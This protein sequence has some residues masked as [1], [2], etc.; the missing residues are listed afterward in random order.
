M[1]EIKPIIKNKNA[2]T[3]RLEDKITVIEHGYF[4]EG[5]IEIKDTK[6][7]DVSQYAEAQVVDENLVSE[8][9]L[10]DKTI[11]GIEGQIELPNEWN[12]E[13]EEE[14]YDVGYTLWDGTY[15]IEGTE[16]AVKGVPIVVS[17][18]EEIPN[19]LK[20]NLVGN[21]IYYV[22]ETTQ[23][24][25][26]NNYYI[27]YQNTNN[28]ISLRRVITPQD[29]L[30][31]KYNGTFDV[32]EYANVFI[33]V[34][35]K[36]YEKTTE[37]ME[38]FLLSEESEFGDVVLNTDINQYNV[39]ISINDVKNYLKLEEEVE[40]W[41]GSYSE[42]GKVLSS[43]DGSYSEIGN[44]IL[45]P[46]DDGVGGIPIEVSSIEQMDALLVAENI[47]KIYKYVGETNE[48]YTNGALYQISEEV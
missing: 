48:K 37:E 30:E 3:I 7:V 29:T 39:I 26:K 35:G 34:K 22:G 44:T 25:I 23:N 32:T 47:G 5:R 20:S 24:Y 11:L 10:K 13:F 16:V 40:E 31:I 14:G 17:N 6:V 42:I 12:G 9:I 1:S 27:I 21:V 36:P 2:I 33:N 46:I 28:E 45:P 43:W 38:T 41:N 4:P 15:L 18:A 19:Y 8:N